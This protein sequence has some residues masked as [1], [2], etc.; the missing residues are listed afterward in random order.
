MGDGS[1]TG[2]EKIPATSF[3]SSIGFLVSLSSRMVL[4]GG[5]LLIHFPS[6]HALWHRLFQVMGLSWV[7]PRKFDDFVLQWRSSR[8]P[9]RSRLLCENSRHLRLV[10][11]AREESEGI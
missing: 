6:V 9:P 10:D 1:K 8:V 4:I 2:F 5:H 3:C 7:A 11:L